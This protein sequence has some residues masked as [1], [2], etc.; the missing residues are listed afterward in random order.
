MI[1]LRKRSAASAAVLISL[2]VAGALLYR[3]PLWVSDQQVRLHLWRAGVLSHYVTV[4]G[5]RVHYFE[6]P[7]TNGTSGTPLVLIHGL[8][9]RGEDWSPLIPGLAAA[10]FHVYVPDLLGYGR[11]QHPDISYSIKTEETVVADFLRTMHVDQADVAGWS[12]GGW[13][14]MK[15][16]LD[17]P[18]LVSR[19]V[20]FDS[21]GVYFQGYSGIE[22]IFDAKDPAGVDRLFALLTPHPRSIPTFV[23][24]NLVRRIQGNMWVLR[25]SINSM[26]SGRDILDFRLHAIQQPTL[27]IWGKQDR[28]IP[29]SSGESIHRGIG[30]SSMLVVDG[31]GHLTPAECSEVSMR[32]TIAFFRA[33]P[34]IR[35]AENVVNAEVSSSVAVPDKGVRLR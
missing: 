5:Y 30:G 19:L 16:A 31:C 23:A 21:A 20:L 22:A 35:G 34:P 6:A 27:V 18:G 29:L 1:A 32:A 8:G 7:A 33:E 13:I 9:A 4:D 3:N 14:A 24:N 15:L 12:M 11:S 26:V 10:G 2:I 28:L 17:D 25:R